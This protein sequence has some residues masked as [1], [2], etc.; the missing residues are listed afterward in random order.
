MKEGLASVDT[1]SP[2]LKRELSI[3]KFTVLVCLC[4]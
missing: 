1:N 2:E 3:G 4:E